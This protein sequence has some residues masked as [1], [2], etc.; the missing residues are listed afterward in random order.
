[1]K[2]LITGIA[3]LFIFSSCASTELLRMSVLQ[4]A[5]VTLPADIKNVIVVNRTNPSSKSKIFDVIDKAVTMEGAH[6]DK[7]GAQQ[8]SI[9][10]ADELR[11]NNRFDHVEMLPDAELT[12]DVS[13]MFPLPLSWDIV[14]KYGNDNDADAL[15][16]LE[17]FDTDSR[18]DYSVNKTNVKSPFG[19]IP[20]IEQQANILTVVKA[21]WRIYDIKGHEILDKAL[22]S[23]ALTYRGRGI[24]PL[25]AAQ[26]LI[27]R[28]EAVKEVGNTAGHAY[29]F[30]IIPMWIR[31]PRIYYVRGN[32]N[33]KIAK[34]MA[35]TGN[36]DGAAKLWQR[37]TLNT[38]RKVAG[39]ACYNMAIISEINGD[40]NRAI[41]WAQQAYENY[42]N[43]L[44][45]S[46]INILK[47]RQANDALA[48]EQQVE[49]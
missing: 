42:N 20:A 29:A 21:G 34:R 12:T 14:D 39:R 31:V 43:R 17:F 8:A 23:K 24:N 27:D 6:L 22:I 38:K 40:P 2:N 15:F 3:T 4:P 1:M 10:L 46:Y 18:I 7:E 49:L 16:S 37:E 30:R 33:F 28:K 48:A 36:W 19:N 5:P 45:L 9:G 32:S 44:A 26:A 13:G 41:Q 11:K 35:R 25:L 47:N